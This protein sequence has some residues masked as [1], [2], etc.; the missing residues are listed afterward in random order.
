MSLSVM[1]NASGPLTGTAAM[2]TQRSLMD[3]DEVEA[4]LTVLA[5][6]RSGL[7][8][9]A[10]SLSC[11]DDCPGPSRGLFL[12]QYCADSPSSVDVCLS[13]ATSS[14]CTLGT[15]PDC[16]PCP[17]GAYCTCGGVVRCERVRF[18]TVG[19]IVGVVAHERQRLGC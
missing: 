6:S 17:D 4:E 7:D 11:P 14:R 13:D 15:P 16:T 8:D 5:T 9:V 2:P 10:G 1:N 3:A 18:V 12:T 19:C